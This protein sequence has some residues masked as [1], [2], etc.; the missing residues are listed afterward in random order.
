MS[1]VERIM[2]CCHRNDDLFRTYIACLLQLKHH[3]EVSQKMYQ[4]LKA[5][6]LIK[7]IC[8]REVDGIIKE[9]KE[10]KLYDLPKVLKWDFLRNNPLM[11]E[12]VCTTL[13]TYE[14]LHLSCEE[15]INIIR[16]IENE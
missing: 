2:R 6:F 12:T 14:K 11:I 3:S 4:E 1:E 9:S 13:F 10:Y 16:C 7:G 8:E 5:D 15:W